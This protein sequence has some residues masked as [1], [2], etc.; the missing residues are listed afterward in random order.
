VIA[1]L[2]R[3]CQASVS[4]ADQRVAAIGPGVVALVC[5]V[6]NDTRSEADALLAKLF[7][8]RIFADDAGKMNR[9]L[10]T[11]QGAL[12]LVPQFTLAADLRGGNRPSFTAAA[13]PELGR[14]LFD[15]V[16]EQA[17]ERCES[18]AAGVFGANMQVALVNDGPVTIWLEVQP[19][20]ARDARQAAGTCPPGDSA[21]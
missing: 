15:Y 1:L 14:D 19:Q 5:A 11:S 7:R 20:Q 4:I 10:A 18:V 6:R 3:V 17:G 21:A 8:L 2:Q 13:P 12:L 16:V 9:D